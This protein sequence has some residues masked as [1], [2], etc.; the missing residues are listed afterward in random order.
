M[1]GGSPQWRGEV[2]LFWAGAGKHFDCQIDE[3]SLRWSRRPEATEQEAKLDG[4]YVMHTSEPV[5]RLSTAD[6]VRSYKR[7][8]E[9]ER[10]FRCRKRIDLL[11][12]YSSHYQFHPALFEQL[13]EPGR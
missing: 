8:A 1:C 5:E 11:V 6:T 4:I 7:L 10:A 13:L 2:L 12:L 3:G 9:V